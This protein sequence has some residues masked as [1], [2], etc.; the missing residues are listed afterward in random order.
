MSRII[1]KQIILTGIIR[2][3][4]Q[5]PIVKSYLDYK[6]SDEPEMFKVFNNFYF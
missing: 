4:K 5:L 2:V 6:Q 3:H 1:N